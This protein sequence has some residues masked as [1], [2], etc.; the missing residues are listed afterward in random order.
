MAWRLFVDSSNGVT[1]E[2]EYDFAQ[3]DELILNAHRARGGRNYRYK[4]GSFNKWKM[5]VRYV[6][7]SFM[8]VV[9]SYWTSNTTLLFKSESLSAV[10]T[11]ALIN[12]SLPIANFEKPYIDLYKGII[13]LETY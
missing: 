6:N 13:E 9:N 1:I 4:W 2:P 12:K 8:S 3:L 7:S 11:V 5:S 10:Y